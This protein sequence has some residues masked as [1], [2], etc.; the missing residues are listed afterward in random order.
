MSLPLYMDHHVRKAITRGLR[1]RG[2]DVLTAHDDGFAEASDEAILDR[3]AEL[4]RVVFSN[5]DDFLALARK[6]QQLGRPFAG[7]VYVHQ[8]QLT[9]GQTIEYLELI[10]QVASAEEMRNAVQFIP[11]R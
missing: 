5:D 10:S 3:A 9:V 1:G 11:L 4:G 8:Q 7:I 2:I 6:W